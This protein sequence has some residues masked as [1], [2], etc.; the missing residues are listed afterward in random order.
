MWIVGFVCYTG[1][2]TKLILN[3]KK[4]GVKYSRVERLMSNLMVAVLVIQIVLCTICSIFTS[5]FLNNNLAN[6]SYLPKTDYTNSV[7]ALISYFTY[8]LLLNTMIPISLIITLELI[9][10]IQGFFMSC[11]V[12][13]YSHVTE[14][15]VKAGSISLNEELGHVNYIFSDK[16]GTLTCNKMLFKY[17]VIGEIC[18]EYIRS[19]VLEKQDPKEIQERSEIRKK[20]DII[21]FGPKFMEHYSNAVPFESSKTQ[22]CDNDILNYLL[23]E[24]TIINE[25]WK[26]LSMTHECTIDENSQKYIGLSPDDIELLKASKDQGYEYTKGK[27]NNK[28]YIKIRD[29]V[30][31]F[32][33]LIIN[34]FSSERRR[35]SIIINDNGTIKLYSKGADTEMVKRLSKNSNEKFIS[36]SKKFIDYFSQFGFRTLFVAMK[37]IDS[38]KFED[39]NTRYRSASMD[40]KHKKENI[41]ELQNEIESGLHLIG[42]TIVEDKLQDKVPD[43]IR[44]LKLAGIKIWM[45]TGDKFSTAFNIGLSCNLVSNEMKIFKIRGERGENMD[46]LIEEFSKFYNHNNVDIQDLPPYGIVIDS[47]ALTSIIG[48]K[49]NLSNFLLIAHNANSV[50]CCRVS[51]LQKAQVVKAMKEYKK[52]SVIIAIGDGGNDVSM[53]MEAHIG[54][55]HNN[56]SRNRRLRRRRNESSSSK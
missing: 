52:E 35:M 36:Q 16:T 30:K 27:S 55:L 47:A 3:S 44:D 9:K 20:L 37:I 8:M 40:F 45:L 53:L 6:A 51:P 54:T 23:D 39:W 46:F 7:N 4:A 25:F 56:N 28:R 15:Y 50:I 38:N 13:M 22:I 32:E 11:D 41:E 5:Y 29:E 2:N 42:A 1:P 17:C 33:I 10:I 48:D 26:A 49:D 14:R 34:E 31:E 21:E 19:S 12:E 24:S 18:Y 43:T